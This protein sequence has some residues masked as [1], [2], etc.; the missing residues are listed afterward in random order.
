MKTVVSKQGAAESDA[1]DASLQELVNAW[2]HL[3]QPVR[4]AVNV[5]IRMSRKK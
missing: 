3:P 2:K 1:P 4:N 5:M